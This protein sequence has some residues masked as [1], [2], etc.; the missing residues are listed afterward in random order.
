MNTEDDVLRSD[1]VKT[2]LISEIRDVCLGADPYVFKQGGMWH[3]L[4]QDNVNSNPDAHDGILGYSVR[5]ASTV[6][7][8]ISSPPVPLSVSHQPPNL[9]QAWAAEILFE[10]YLYV[11]LSDGNNTTHRM[12][13]YETEGDVSGPWKYLGPMSIPQDD[14]YWAIDLTL[15]TITYEGERRHFAVWS[16][17]EHNVSAETCEEALANVVP[18]SVYIAEFI[19]PTEIGSRHL[20]LRPEYEWCSSV[21]PILEGPQALMLKDEFRGLLITGNASWTSEY[22]T[23]FLKYVGGNPLDASSWK[24]HGELLFPA[25]NG[26]GHGVC[27]QDEDT[28]YYIGHR[29][30]SRL[31]GWADRVVFSTRFET[32]KFVQYVTGESHP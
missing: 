26:I 14:E 4:V 30:S 13:V 22:A 17:W 16:G 23:H 31:P 18:Q 19:S 10:K 32:E 28:V 8:L 27:V 2:P 11:S 25:G 12:H 29:K 20:L 7:G 21:M 15:A 5:S 6:E 24:L 1:A 9:R 3:L